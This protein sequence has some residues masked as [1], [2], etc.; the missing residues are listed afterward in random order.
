MQILTVAQVKQICKNMFGT[1]TVMANE[2]CG[3]IVGTN[4]Y[5]CAAGAWFKVNP[6]TWVGIPINNNEMLSIMSSVVIAKEHNM[7][8]E[9]CESYL[10]EGSGSDATDFE[11]ALKEWDL[12]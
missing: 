10:D 2:S 4:L 1:T 5:F 9:V 11:N 6:K 7:L 8:A 12:I 3:Y